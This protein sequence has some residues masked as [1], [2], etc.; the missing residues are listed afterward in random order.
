MSEQERARIARERARIAA[1]KRTESQKTRWCVIFGD[2]ILRDYATEQA[3]RAHQAELNI[4][5]TLIGPDTN[6]SSSG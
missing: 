5:T 6:P 4:V 3:A 2:H 1:G